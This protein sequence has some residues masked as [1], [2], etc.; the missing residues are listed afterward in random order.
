MT[1]TKPGERTGEKDKERKKKKKSKRQ[2]L[3]KQRRHKTREI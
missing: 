2:D 1:Y 3:Y